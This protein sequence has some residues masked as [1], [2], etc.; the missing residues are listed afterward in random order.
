MSQLTLLRAVV[1]LDATRAFLHVGI[2]FEAE[3]AR[4]THEFSARLRI[5]RRER[6]ATKFLSGVLLQYTQ[7]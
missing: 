4:A 6:V 2:R 1:R 7:Q 3:V 5:H